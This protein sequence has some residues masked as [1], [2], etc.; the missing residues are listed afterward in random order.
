MIDKEALQLLLYAQ[1]FYP[2]EYEQFLHNLELRSIPIDFNDMRFIE[3]LQLFRKEFS[4]FLSHLEQP[5]DQNEL[6]Q[7]IPTKDVLDPLV[8][9][10]EGARSDRAHGE[11][12]ESTGIKVN[13]YIAGLKKQRGTKE[14]KKTEPPIENERVIITEVAPKLVEAA[15]FFSKQTDLPA[16]NQGRPIIPKGFFSLIAQTPVQKIIAPVADLF[17]SQR[18][19]AAVI[20]SAIDKA[21][22]E[23]RQRVDALG[24]SV[25]GSDEIKRVFSQI[26]AS[27]FQQPNIH[28]STA[29]GIVD[30][31][32]DA[33]HTV[34]G[35]Q[36]PPEN[37][38]KNKFFANVFQSAFIEP[39][40][41]AIYIAVYQTQPVQSSWS[42]MSAIVLQLGGSAAWTVGKKAAKEAGKVVVE[43]AATT[44][45][46]K[47]I[48]AWLGTLIGPG[49]GTV[50]GY[51]LGDLIL[52]KAL[53]FIGTAVRGV[54]N[55]LSFDWL[56]RIFSGEISETP[57]ME[58]PGMK[59]LVYGTVIFLFILLFPLF[60]FGTIFQQLA[61][62]NA[63]IQGLGY[64]GE[65]QYVDCVNQPDD[66]VCSMT[67]CDP[68]KQ[69]CRWPT[70]GT[71]TQG[72][73]TTCGGTHAHANAIDIGAVMGTDVYATIDGVVI[74]VFTGCPDGEGY[75]GNPCGN[76]LGN[77]VIIKGVN[78]TLKFGHL[79]SSIPVYEGDHVSPTTVIGQVNHSGSS[80]GQHLHFSYS[81]SGSINSILP[82]AIDH[83]S[84]NTI[85]CEPC[86]Y[87]SVGSL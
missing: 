10:L 72:P 28:P 2:K 74:T 84:N 40:L 47:S 66:P 53:S 43:K 48:G 82:F 26:T 80:S 3:Q 14:D 70:S 17:L 78:Y 4:Q 15:A 71:I 42:Q 13:K 20:Q 35:K 58:Q 52:D 45:I 38:G 1:K 22:E 21:Y 36:I 18:D 62:D 29:G 76:Y 34:F 60:G 12:F 49:P 54:F 56:T 50:I 61:D 86:N 75:L 33:V 46:G 83:C 5:I 64:G 39:E 32:G 19:K 68:S 9:E 65:G 27:A 41:A 37:V 30:F 11:H 67:P 55:F 59:W 31:F 44:A 23:I 81:G 63:F 79:L 69:D 8:Q 87:P 16:D 85:G 57:F 7:S 25:A 77:H 73:F 6:E 24:E 51:I